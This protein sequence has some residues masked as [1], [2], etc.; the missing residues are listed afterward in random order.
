MAGDAGGGF[1]MCEVVKLE[2]MIPPSHFE[3]LRQ[4]L[5]QADAGHIGKYDR[6]LSWSLV[7]SAWRPLDGAEPY[8]GTVGK[9]EEAEEYKVE[10]CCRR[11]R[12]AETMAAIRRVHPYEKP[13]I[14][15]IPL[16]G[17]G[18]EELSE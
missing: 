14:Y 12:L 15:V 10:V 5:G 4:A 18:L 6:C 16:V 1:Y 11:D 2:I 13:V 9:V 7:R 17:T 3:A 8:C